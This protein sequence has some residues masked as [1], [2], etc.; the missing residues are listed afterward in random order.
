MW[1]AASQ[2]AIPIC[3]WPPHVAS[4]QRGNKKTGAWFD[5]II[6]LRVKEEKIG[7]SSLFDLIKK[8][9]SGE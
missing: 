4:A 1:Q 7:E 5:A 6:G 8:V 9:E 3:A 2:T